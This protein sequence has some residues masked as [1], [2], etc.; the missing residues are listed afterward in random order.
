MGPNHSSTHVLRPELGF[1]DVTQ[2]VY[3][4]GRTRMGPNVHILHC[5]SSGFTNNYLTVANTVQY[6]QAAAAAAA[7]TIYEHFKTAEIIIIIIIIQGGAN[8][9]LTAGTTY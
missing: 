1:Y 9:L 2:Q 4:Y 5:Q 3:P 6:R 8:Y 7:E